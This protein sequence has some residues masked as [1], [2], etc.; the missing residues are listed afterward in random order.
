[1][2]MDIEDT[3]YE[4]KLLEKMFN[5]EEEIK[6]YLI[7]IGIDNKTAEFMSQFKLD[8]MENILNGKHHHK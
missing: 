7:S 6:I 3:D 2:S 8:D 5:I 4:D 1:M